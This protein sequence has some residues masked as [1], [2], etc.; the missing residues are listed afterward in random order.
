MSGGPVVDRE[1]RLV[2]VM[3]RATDD[4]D[5]VQYVRAVRMSHVAAQLAGA[6]D[7]L[8]GDLQDSVAGYLE[9]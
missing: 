4:H 7:A 6:F 2:G 9:R 3:V 8:P 5:G 1:G